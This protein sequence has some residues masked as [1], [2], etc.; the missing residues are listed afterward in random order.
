MRKMAVDNLDYLPGDGET[1]FVIVSAAD[2]ESHYVSVHRLQ[3][4]QRELWESIAKTFLTAIRS[5]HHV[6]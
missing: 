1:L 4:S 6:V 2:E 5:K 3:E